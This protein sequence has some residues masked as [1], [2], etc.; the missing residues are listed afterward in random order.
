MKLEE[1]LQWRAGALGAMA[2]FTVAEVTLTPNLRATAELFQLL[3]ER[4]VSLIEDKVANL[5]VREILEK[6]AQTEPQ[7]AGLLEFFKHCDAMQAE[8]RAKLNG[9]ISDW[10]LKE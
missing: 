5:L 1:L 10:P 3:S 2:Q 8:Y 9:V 4:L 6:A 7:F